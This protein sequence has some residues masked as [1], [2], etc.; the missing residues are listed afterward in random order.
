VSDALQRMLSPKSIAIVGVSSDFNKL[1][2]RPMKFLLDKGYAGAIYPVNPKYE[3]IA[4]IKCYPSVLDLPEPVDLAVVAVPAK[5]VL[6]TITQLGEAKVASA[7]IFSSG[8]G[9][10][11][12]EG[13]ALEEAV[14][15]AAREGD[16]RICGPNCLGLINAFEGTMA[17]FSQ[18]ADADTPAGPIAFVTQSGAF[19][20]A[21]NALARNRHLGFGLFVNTG[22][23]ADVNF[24]SGMSAVLD[25]PRI[26]VGAGYIEGLKDGEGLVTLAEKAMTLEKP[27]VL[28]KVGRYGAGARAAASHTGS[29]A[30]EDAIFDGVVRQ[31]GILRGRNEEHML[32]L[33]QALAYTDLPTG[34]GVGIVTQSGGAGVLM[35]DRAEELGLE[36]P[37]LSADTTAALKEAIPAFGATGNPVDITGQFLAEPEIL[38]NSVNAVLE[39]PLVDIAVVWLQLMEG[40]TDLLIDLFTQIKMKAQKPFIVCWVA[41]SETALQR[42]GE[43]GVAVMRGADPAIEAVAGLV[44]YR[45]ARDAWRAEKMLRQSPSLPSVP[46]PPEI[47]V[48]PTVAA[49]KALIAAEVS[50]TRH[51]LCQSADE[52]CIAAAAIGYPVAMKIESA[53]LPHKTEAGGVLLGLSDEDAVRSAYDEIVRNARRFKVDAAIDGLIIQEMAKGGLELVVGLKRDPVFGMVI[54]VGLGGVFVEVLRDVVFRKAPITPAQAEDMLRSLQGAAML[55][56]VRGAPPVNMEALTE[57]IAAVSRFG[58]G[59][60]ERVAELDLNPVLAGPERAV[61]VDWLLIQDRDH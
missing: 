37:Q 5:V 61:A 6:D 39:D 20:T 34:R 22:N 21:I 27:I 1:N 24:V 42:L 58:A 43:I 26:A 2:G 48:V 13:K 19:G 10:M 52:A 9:E 12:S 7:V 15:V 14:A 41:A 60:S 33:V 29:L 49:A 38:L 47:G 16:V 54:M 23:E 53:D 51:T 44:Q 57:L 31:L 35:A 59:A 56:G 11:G 45:E 30:G 17:T 3:E 4:G 50:L 55:D 28:T 32:D 46:L 8:F 18:Y 25:D 36:V 40:Y